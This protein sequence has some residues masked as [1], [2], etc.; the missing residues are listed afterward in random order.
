MNKV[1]MRSF[2]FERIEDLNCDF[3]LLMMLSSTFGFEKIVL[4]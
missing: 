2:E 1:V 3:E 4:I